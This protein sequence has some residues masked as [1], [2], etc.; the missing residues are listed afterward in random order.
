[1]STAAG[2]PDAT[3]SMPIRA[4]NELPDSLLR[5][6]AILWQRLRHSGD[7]A[8]VWRNT[9][10]PASHMENWATREFTTGLVYS[11]RTMRRASSTLSKSVKPHFL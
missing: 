8:Q 3:P 5:S 2:A 9:S 6:F 11:C 7:C 4:L 1:M 10:I